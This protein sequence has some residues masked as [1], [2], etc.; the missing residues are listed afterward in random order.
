MALHVM[1]V[2]FGKLGKTKMTAVVD[3]EPTGRET[4]TIKTQKKH[5]YL[6]IS[7][8]FAKAVISDHFMFFS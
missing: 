8:C 4:S 5:P 2:G 3:K 6:I 7:L 1:Q